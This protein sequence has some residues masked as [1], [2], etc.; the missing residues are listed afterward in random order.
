MCARRLRRRLTP[1]LA[2]NLARARAQ[3]PL[4]WT[5]AW[6]AYRADVGGARYGREWNAS[7]GLPFGPRWR[8]LAKVADY[9]A[10]TYARD[11]TKLWLQLEW[12][13][14]AK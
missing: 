11:T 3:G 9:R 4:E 5:V 1:R 8:A 10:A 14:P 12:A 13:S 2:H 6:H 7:L